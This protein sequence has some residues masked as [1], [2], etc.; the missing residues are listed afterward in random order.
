M[1]RMGL[2]HATLGL[3]ASKPSISVENLISVI[4]ADGL[5]VTLLLDNASMDNGMIGKAV[6]LWP[7]GLVWVGRAVISG[8][9]IHV[10]IDDTIMVGTVPVAS[11]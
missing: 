7:T 6:G 4:A 2:R 11:G 9:G 1:R 10:D 3:R 8:A 5:G